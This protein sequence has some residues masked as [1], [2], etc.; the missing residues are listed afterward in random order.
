MSRKRSAEDGGGTAFYKKST[1]DDLDRYAHKSGR[2]N[3]RTGVS[4][5]FISA[6]DRPKVKVP[7]IGPAV[8]DKDGEADG[9]VLAGVLAAGAGTA[10]AATLGGAG[11][12]YR[13]DIAEAAKQARASIDRARIRAR[14]GSATEQIRSTLRRY[15][16]G[17]SGLSE[18]LISPK[19]VGGRRVDAY[20]MDEH[21]GPQN[22]PQKRLNQADDRAVRAENLPKSNPGRGV[23]GQLSD[24]RNKRV[25][26]GEGP[27]AQ[28]MKAYE[29]FL[30]EMPTVEELQAINSRLPPERIA[31]IHEA[32]VKAVNSGQIQSGHAKNI[33][34]L[35]Q[36][37]ADYKPTAEALQEE[38]QRIRNLTPSQKAEMTRT[39]AAV[40][41]KVV[42][43]DDIRQRKGA[44]AAAVKDALN[45]ADDFRRPTR[46]DIR[47]GMAKGARGVAPMLGTMVGESVADAL[48]GDDDDGNLSAM[49]MA[50]HHGMKA[51]AGGAGA[52]L[53][54]AAAGVGGV[55]ATAAGA[56]IGVGLL[57]SEGVGA[58]MD[59]TD[60][61]GQGETQI[62]SSGVGMG[63]GGAT[64]EVVAT[65][66]AGSALDAA[67]IGAA[68]V[69][70]GLAAAGFASV[71]YVA[72]EY[73]ADHGR[74]DH[75]ELYK[76]H[77]E[78]RKAG[79]GQG[80]QSHV[81]AG[82]VGLGKEADAQLYKT[83]EA[84]AE[85]TSAAIRGAGS[86]I[87]TATAPIGKALGIGG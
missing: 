3:D 83:V 20:N 44:R 46:A 56:G 55:A 69:G 67:A 60:A 29:E 79:H 11:Y 24:M 12:A 80:A 64:T 52:G 59:E 65:L 54:A 34:D 28:R 22:R 14:V 51:T 41:Q 58:A 40:G 9:N 72:N 71:A 33:A 15:G 78:A 48:I 75:V 6:P 10:L 45:K 1:W 16:T 87:E 82:S 76:G 39:Q 77:A 25:G 50:E 42:K 27:Q 8:E 30:R 2:L 26:A 21:I 43:N 61:F 68:G 23:G 4:Q 85:P 18:P 84:V 66:A 38:A 35:K 31:K 74:A 19:P 81:A 47:K 7:R 49:E 73:E 70:A 5:S 53:F 17:R 13:S 63:V 57:A 36:K 32:Y 37:I 86:A 62:I